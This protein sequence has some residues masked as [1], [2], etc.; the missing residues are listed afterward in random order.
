MWIPAA[1][2]QHKLS[3]IA[4]CFLFTHIR[5]WMSLLFLRSHS[6]V[7][8]VTRI[9]W[10]PMHGQLTSQNYSLIISTTRSSVQHGPSNL[11]NMHLLSSLPTVISLDLT[12]Q[13]QMFQLCL[14]QFLRN[15]SL[16]PLHLAVPLANLGQ[17]LFSAKRKKKAWS[18]IW[19]ICDPFQNH[20]LWNAGKKIVAVELLQ[21]VEG[22][23]K[24]YLWKRV[25]TQKQWK[26]GEI[27]AGEFLNGMPLSGPMSIYVL[28]QAGI[29]GKRKQCRIQSNSQ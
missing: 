25:T 11:Y 3:H 10:S 13:F 22:K 16:K 2:M 7:N 28:F 26:K 15:T 21:V 17:P 23:K 24:M 29:A 12:I 14:T 27:T 20:L 19:T 9:F 4:D 1:N 18:V 6:D 8:L 5:T